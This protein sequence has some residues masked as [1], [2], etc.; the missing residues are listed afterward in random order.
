MLTNGDVK[1]ETA[2]DAL[3]LTSPVSKLASIDSDPPAEDMYI[4]TQEEKVSHSFKFFFGRLK[5]V[6]TTK[7]VQ[8]SKRKK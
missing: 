3:Q 6:R 1:I 7:I 8:R 4:N 2:A 5:S